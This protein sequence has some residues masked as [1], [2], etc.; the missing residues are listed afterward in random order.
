MANHITGAIMVR[1]RVVVSLRSVI[2]AKCSP[3][4]GAGNIIERL[5]LRGRGLE[6]AVQGKKVRTI[7]YRFSPQM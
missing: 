3:G 5:R 4:C 6:V 2:Q 7:F 1:F